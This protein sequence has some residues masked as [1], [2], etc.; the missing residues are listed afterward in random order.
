MRYLMKGVILFFIFSISI[1]ATALGSLTEY[2]FFLD[3]SV[4]QYNVTI[5]KPVFEID[6]DYDFNKY[7]QCYNPEN[8]SPVVIT[9]RQQGSYYCTQTSTLDLKKNE[10]YGI[11]AS[12]SITTNGKSLMIPNLFYEYDPWDEYRGFDTTF[13]IYLDSQGQLAYRI[14]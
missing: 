6:K 10:S 13:V 11:Y 4:Q 14:V 9:G 12:I 8:Q 2:N 5:N 1:S 3:K 7:I